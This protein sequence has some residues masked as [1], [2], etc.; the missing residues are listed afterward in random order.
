MKS[1]CRL[2]AALLLPAALAASAGAQTNWTSIFTNVPKAR[3]TVFPRRA[4]ILCIQVDGLGYGDLSCYGQQRYQTPTLDKLAAG[5]IRFTNYVIDG[6]T[7]PAHAELMTGDSPAHLPQ[8]ADADVPLTAGQQTA[9]QLLQD[10]GYRTGLIGYWDLGS[11][12]SAGAPW[13]KGFQ[14]FA[15]YF[16]PGDAENFYADYIFRYAPNA[17]RGAN[18][19]MEAFVGRE[20]IYPNT[21]GK[22]GE[23]M[24]DT[25]SKAA[26]N[27]IRIRHPDHFNRYQPF[28]LQV[29]FRIPNGR[30][31]VPSDAPFSEES[32]S[33]AAKD[34]AAFIS[35]LDGYVGNML[36]E[37]NKWGMTN[38]VVIFFAGASQPWKTA[39][40]DPAFFH[41]TAGPTDRREP[42]I[43]YWPGKITA[44]RIDGQACS[45]ADFL[46]TAA[47]IALLDVPEK[48]DGKSLLR[49]LI[50][51][52]TPAPL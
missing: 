11:E 14:E 35:R 3:T 25:L 26:V 15:G 7:A 40:F 47:K 13:R 39:E 43:V 6:A 36:E 42:L 2:A 51:S 31:T 5:G 33:Q 48:L 50:G 12:N 22:K 38:N 49:S 21:D 23:Y 9:A 8:R 46:P 32:W 52:Q 10:S 18:N 4:S 17:I 1:F 19:Q 20:M 37:L 24:P 44:G 41:S 16:D 34:R 28:Y 27:F 29:N 30:I 45:P